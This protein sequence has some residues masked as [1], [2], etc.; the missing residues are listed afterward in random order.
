[1]AKSAAMCPGRDSNPHGAKRSKAGRESKAGNPHCALCKMTNQEC[2]R[3]ELARLRA[4][5]AELKRVVV[6]LK[7]SAKPE[8]R[9]VASRLSLIAA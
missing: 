5:R 9:A 8:L 2:S 6:S 4:E 3:C 1:M 7:K